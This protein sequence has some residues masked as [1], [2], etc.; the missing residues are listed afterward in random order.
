ML[1]TPRRI[2]KAR[3]IGG[4]IAHQRGAVVGRVGER[5]LQLGFSLRLLFCFGVLSGF[6]GR[7]GGIRLLRHSSI[8]QKETACEEREQ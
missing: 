1:G 3:E 2:R 6:G 4:E 8:R 7:R 5:L